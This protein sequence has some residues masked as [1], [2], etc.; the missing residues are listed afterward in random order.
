MDWQ[1]V[2]KEAA[3]VVNR[4][5]IS[6]IKQNIRAETETHG[7]NF[8][9]IVNFKEYCDE[10]DKLYVFKINH[11][12]GNPDQPSFVFKTSEAKIKLAVAMDK[13][14][15]DFLSE[16]FSFFDGKHNRCQGFITLTASVYHPLLPKQIHQLSW[17]QRKKPQKTL[18]CFGNFSTR[19]SPKHPTETVRVSIQSVG[20]WI[21]QA[22]TLL[23]L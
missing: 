21:W 22:P 2:E 5:Q 6:N 11:R 19:P 15:E 4:K 16:E 20:A 13:E 17:R 14:K 3:S 12:R 1:T 9:A 18:N 7:H 23:E 10:K 8:E